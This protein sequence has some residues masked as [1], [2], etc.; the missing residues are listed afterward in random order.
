MLP[1]VIA[2]SASYTAAE[3]EDWNNRILDIVRRFG[4]D[5]YPQ[6]FEICDHE[7]YDSVFGYHKK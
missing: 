6:E 1:D 4:L 5:A 2:M 7:H 3:L